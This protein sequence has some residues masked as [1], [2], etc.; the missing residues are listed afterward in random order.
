MKNVLVLFEFSNVTLAQY[1]KCWADLRASGN[2]Q[3]QGLISHMGAQNG[4][5]M[6]VVDQWES[7]EAFAAFGDTLMPI[8]AKND[9]PTTQPRIL[10]LHYAHKV[11]ATATANMD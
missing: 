7:A 1:D 6:V 3:P 8:L 11:K 5:G 9:I 10:P 4:T 2:D